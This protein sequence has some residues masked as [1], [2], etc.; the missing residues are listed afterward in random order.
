LIFRL[1][2]PSVLTEN[3]RASFLRDVS[4]TAVAWMRLDENCMLSY[5]VFVDGYA[6]AYVKKLQG[7]L[8]YTYDQHGTPVR[9]QFQLEAFKKYKVE[10]FSLRIL[11]AR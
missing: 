7:L 9:K 5:Y 1:A 4:G 10:L 6:D 8:V 3:P 2:F 11:K